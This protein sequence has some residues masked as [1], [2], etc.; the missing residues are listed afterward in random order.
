[1]SF[2]RS[3][4]QDKIAPAFTAAQA[5]FPSVKKDRNVD[6]GKYS[7]DYADLADVL[8]TV[9]PVLNKHGLALLQ[10]PSTDEQGNVVITTHLLHVSGQWMESDFTMAA[11]DNRDA[12]SMGSAVTY[13]RRYGA[14]GMLGI[15]PADG[16]DD[17]G[18]A[19]RGG[20]H[21]MPKPAPKPPAARKVCPICA[22]DA[23]RQNGK[24]GQWFCSKRDG[25]CGKNWAAGPHPADVKPEDFAL[26]TTGT[27]EQQANAL[28]SDPAPD[29][30]ERIER[31]ALMGRVKAQ[32]DMKKMG[33]KERA[34][35]W[36]THCGQAT[37][38]N[39]DVGALGNLL[40]AIGK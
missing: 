16:E 38:E 39:V 3:E 17:D 35:L 14:C 30:A 13:A 26:Q 22:A 36:Q 15:A 40:E 19:A 5:E 20:N 31:A 29:E 24:T 10:P 28:F 27:P 32:A 1:M 4:A 21:E 12:R 8:N 7:Y 37:P 33:A 25:G 18:A 11:V 6:T 34:A 2:R 9:V 23:I